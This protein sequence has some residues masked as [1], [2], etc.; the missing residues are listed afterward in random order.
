M[1]TLAELLPPGNGWLQDETSSLTEHGSGSHCGPPG[2][3]SGPLRVTPWW[4]PWS[5]PQTVSQGRGE[6]PRESPHG[7]HSKDYSLCGAP[8]APD[9]SHFM[10][11]SLVFSLPPPRLPTSMLTPYF[12][13]AGTCD[14]HKRRLK[15]F[16]ANVLNV[17]TIRTPRY[18]EICVCHEPKHDCV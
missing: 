17:H 18:L 4:L 1:P 14:V 10:L 16:M 7:S 13:L 15:G 9:L 3:L 11:T 6:G 8:H 2:P 5:R 12:H